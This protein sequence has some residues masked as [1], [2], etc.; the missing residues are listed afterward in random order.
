MDCDSRG[1]EPA[2]PVAGPATLRYWATQDGFT[3]LFLIQMSAV[4]HQ[5]IA[6]DNICPD[7]MK[8]NEI[9]HFTIINLDNIFIFLVVTGI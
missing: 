1:F 9:E 4:E 2:T 5:I 7:A 8:L 3:T 6:G